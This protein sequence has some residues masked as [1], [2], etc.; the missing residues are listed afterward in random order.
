MRQLH[1]RLIL[2]ALAQALTI[3]AALLSF[4][5]AARAEVC[6]DLWF[7]RNLQMDRAGYCFGSALGKAVFDNSDCA[8]GSVSL[9]AN[10][11][12]L[13]QEVRKLEEQFSC[14]LDSTSTRLDLPDIEIR[15]RLVDHPLPDGFE[16]ACLGWA[17]G[18]TA[19][20][21]GRSASLPVVGAV[22]PGDF[23]RFGHFASDQDDGW[24]YVTVH[25]N[26]FERMKSAGWLRGGTT[27]ECEAYAG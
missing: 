5:G 8:G 2:Q 7:T 27:D 4:S 14:K 11:E 21:A 3:G 23:I 1:H 24:S 15:R 16:S 19:L 26:N 9:D 17:R 20:Y 18:E 22:E 12:A 10:T 13:V 6:A 25:S